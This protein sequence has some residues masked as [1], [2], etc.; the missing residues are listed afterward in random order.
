MIKPNNYCDQ[1]TNVD[2]A[3]T[4]ELATLH[5]TISDWEFSP[6]KEFQLGE[7][8]F[9]VCNTD[10]D[11]QG[12]YFFELLINDI[13]SDKTIWAE[14]FRQFWE[15]PDYHKRFVPGIKKIRVNAHSQLK[16]WMPIYIGKSKHIGKR[17]NEHILLGILKTTFAM[18]LKA[19]TNLHGQTFRVSAI[20]LQVTNY[21]AIMPQIE[22][23]LRNKYNPIIGKQ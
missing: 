3:I 2:Q 14:Q 17:I 7:D 10:H 21:D 4:K 19:R 5:Q 15:H 20:R 18:K 8:T 6:I 23:A 9:E 16:Q 12:I 11:F 1:V 13:T 22:T